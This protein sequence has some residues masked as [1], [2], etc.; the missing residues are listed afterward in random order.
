MKIRFRD[1]ISIIFGATLVVVMD[2]AVMPILVGYYHQVSAIVFFNDFAV[3]LLAGLAGI[4]IASH[5]GSPLW[6][7]HS[8]N[9][10]KLGRATH[11]TAVLGFS[12][13]II[14]TVVNIVYF[15]GN[16]NNALQVSPW[17]AL[18]TPETALAVS[19]RGALNEEV[20]FRLFLF[21]LIARVLRRFVHSQQ[22][23]LVT[24][25][26]ASSIVV[27]FIHPGFVMTFLV[28][29]ALVYVYYRSGLLSAMTVHF[30]ADAIPFVAISVI[31]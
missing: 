21:P 27:G 18:L 8:I 22:L 15:S 2:V 16:R 12:I 9:S 26:F 17:L 28:G 20:L 24:G 29:L 23:S 1:W 31:K 10:S 19:F 14:N 13:V 11:I 3:V 30:F 7:R 5:V 4:L 25:A 6:W